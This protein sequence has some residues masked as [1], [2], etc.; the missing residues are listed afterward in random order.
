MTITP[1]HIHRALVCSCALLFV[2][3]APDA[4]ADAFARQ[5]AP[6]T[7]PSKAWVDDFAAFASAARGKQWIVG[8][9]TSPCLSEGEAFDAASRDAR[10]QLLLRVRPRLSS[11][12]DPDTDAWLRRRLTQELA[13]GNLVSDRQVGR[14]RRSYGDLWSEAILIDASDRR[15]N[16]L[17]REHELWLRSRHDTRRGAAAS[18]VGLSLAILLVYAAVNAVTKGYFRGRLRA[19]AVLSFALG[20]TAVVYYATRATG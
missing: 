3:A 14:V 8:R 13:A 19:G 2:T 6:S 5:T 11:P 15:L 12:R 9:S 1:P 4:S 16:G 18:I 10:D 7:T 20:F 17:V